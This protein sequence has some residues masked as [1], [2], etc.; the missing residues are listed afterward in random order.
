MGPLD[1]AST[2]VRIAAA[3]A[4]L[5]ALAGAGPSW[6]PMAAIL[7]VIALDP[8]VVAPLLKARETHG[9]SLGVGAFA[10]RRWFELSLAA[11]ALAGF[12]VRMKGV[13]IG[14]GHEWLG[15]DESRL[16]E[17]VLGFLRTGTL[18]HGTSEDHPGLHFWLLTIGGIGT[19]LWAL[20]SGL[21]KT[22]EDLKPATVV[23]SG[24]IMNVCIAAGTTVL[25]GL[26]GRFIAG[27]AAG[28]VATA[29]VVLSPV[30]LETATQLRND[31][32]A[33][34]LV[35]FGAYAAQAAIT[36][37]RRFP[38]LA[39]GAIAG[40]A[41]GT[42]ITSVFAL[43]PALLAVGVTTSGRPRWKGFASCAAGFFGAIAVT[44]H[45][46]WSDI[47]TFLG[48]IAM[49]YGHVQKGHFAFTDQPRWGYTSLLADYGVGWPLLL[50]AAGCA[51]FGLA[52]K[53]RRVW[54]LLAFPIPYL[55]F[56]TLK[57]ALFVRWL[58]VLV[59]FIA[60]AG[61]AALVIVI[62]AAKRLPERFVPGL[63]GAMLG[64]ALAAVLALAAFWPVAWPG[65]IQ[66]S[67]RFTAPTYAL[68]EDWLIRTVP[69][70]DLVLAEEAE[71]DLAKGAFRVVR[72]RDLGEALGSDL[73]LSDCKWIVVQEGRFQL[74][75]LDRLF[76][77]REF[78]GDNGFGGGRGLDVRV[79]VPQPP[80]SPSR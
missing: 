4:M 34:F 67:R 62:R 17:S 56:M 24:R 38:A 71:L 52:T 3:T 79:Y 26:V 30:T 11:I 74:P 44:N 12:C 1:R 10:R 33:S 57:R 59:P 7:A 6:L 20:M 64:H 13:D 73:Q 75:G 21:I 35:V 14:V 61:A 43:L 25:T 2:F 70:A 8:A 29:V 80:G 60:V 63:G 37:P 54:V 15:V 68:A 69:K 18:E 22:I 53:N 42:K 55:W 66:I 58:D 9:W 78:T 40:C 36:A 48:Q 65:A 41:T 46:I 77:V 39:L 16:A 51:V 45:F 28:L 19:Y 32:G 47:P 31:V 49:D 76:L 23:A 72:V 27:P 5:V 50:L